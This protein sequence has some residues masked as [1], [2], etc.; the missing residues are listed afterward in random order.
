MAVISSDDFYK[1][2]AD[3]VTRAFFEAAQ[4]RV[5]DAKEILAGSAGNDVGYDR[6]IVG[7]IQ[8]YRE[9]QS[10]HIEDANDD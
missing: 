3:P 5:E 1:W 7:L 8:A 2:K 6:Q 9:M 10:F 4:Q